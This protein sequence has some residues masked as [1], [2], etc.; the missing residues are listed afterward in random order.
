MLGCSRN[1][2]Q[3]I[4]TNICHAWMEPNAYAKTYAN[5]RH[6]WMEPN[7]SMQQ[8][9]KEYVM[10]GWSLKHKQEQ[11]RNMMWLGTFS[12]VCKN[13]Q[14][15]AMTGWRIT[16]TQKTH[17]GWLVPHRNCKHMY[18]EYA[19]AGWC[20]KHVIQKI[21]HGRHESKNYI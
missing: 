1:N 18:K 20:L 10:H 15:Y 6:I 21:C 3:N 16:N 17:C 5:I 7:K 2:T 4:S 12:N 9:Y 19:A 14:K 8:I 13:M 11:I